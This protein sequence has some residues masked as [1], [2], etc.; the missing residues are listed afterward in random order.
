M[1]RDSSYNGDVSSW[2]I[3]DPSFMFVNAKQF[4]QKW[5][6]PKWNG[7][8]SEQDFKGSNGMHKCCSSGTYNVP[9]TKFPFIKCEPCP[10]GTFT[11]KL[12]INTTCTSCSTGKINLAYGSN[13]V[14]DCTFCSAGKKFANAAEACTDCSSGLYQDQNDV[15][16]VTCKDCPAGWHQKEVGKQYCVPCAPGKMQSEQGQEQC[17]DCQIGQFVSKANATTCHKCGSLTGA[18]AHIGG[19]YQ[20]EVGKTKCKWCKPGK[21]SNVYVNYNMTYRYHDDS[22]FLGKWSKDDY[23]YHDDNVTGLTDEMDCMKC[24]IGRYS[25]SNGANKEDTCSK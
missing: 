25:K 5:C 15:P 13:S 14:D 21:W 19:C 8:F 11:D 18:F 12:N 10:P 1:F 16:S 23:R 20:N 6:N 2:T 9:S 24:I 3:H 4:D 7:I 17:K 22:F